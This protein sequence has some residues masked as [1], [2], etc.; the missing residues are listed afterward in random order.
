MGC[1]S[2]LFIEIKSSWAARF[3]IPEGY[4]W[5]LWAEIPE[6]RD[7]NIYGALAGVRANCPSPVVSPRGIPDDIGYRVKEIMDG[8]EGDFHSHTWLTVLEFISA[9]DSV[10]DAR[11]SDEESIK[12][13]GKNGVFIYKPWIAAKKIL[14]VLSEV[15]GIENIR[16]IIAFDN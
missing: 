4:S 14:G 3:N 1:N 5:D 12:I 9:I 11:K 13:W 15:Y 10:D 7:Y 6:C 8:N 2:H 16:I